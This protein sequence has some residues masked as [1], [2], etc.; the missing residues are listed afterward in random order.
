M[1]LVNLPVL[2]TSGDLLPGGGELNGRRWAGQQLLRCWARQAGER[3]LAL[4]NADPAQLKQLE[5]WLRQQGF[6]GILHGLGLV[7]PEPCRR[8]G[9]L[10]LPDPSIGRW[11]QWRQPAGAAAFSLIGQIHTLST[12]AALGHLQDLVSEPVQP[13]DALICSSRAGRDA[14]VTVLAAREEQLLQRTAGSEEQLQSLRPQLPVIPLPLPPESLPAEPLA[15]GAA[16]RALGIAPAEAVVLWLGRLS[17]YTKLDPWPAYTVLERVARQLPGP[18]V[19]IECGPDDRP[20]QHLAWE[21]LR[22]LCPAV[23]FV[24]LGGEQPVPEEVKHQA[25]AAA[26]VALS[27]VDNAQET[28]GLAV[29]EAMAAGLP[30]VASDWSGYRDLVGHGREGFLVPSRWAAVAPA[31][32]PALGWQ[33]FTGLQ[34]FPAVAGALAQLVQ[35]DLAAAEIALLTLLTTP[36]LAKAMGA[37]G[38]RKARQTLAP[39]VVME[40]YEELFAELTARRQQAPPMATQPQPVSPQLDPVRVFAGFASETAAPRSTPA[41]PADLGQLPQ[42]VRDQ[43]FQLWDLLQYSASGE[44]GS[45]LSAALID[46]LLLKHDQSTS[47]GSLET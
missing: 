2:I 33:Q 47:C 39:P 42:A 29:A 31:L 34:G 41:N 17:L 26:D 6:A 4:A 1:A 9:G 37:A 11:A 8:W 15:R 18:L 20:S 32:S 10:F 22:Q 13:W 38:A 35:L 3:P 19:L 24:R 25:L 46:A 40:A 5:P 43:R 21:Q 45:D 14:V 30:V 27:L 44:R 16:R 23:R 7:D 36:A 12:P 28:F